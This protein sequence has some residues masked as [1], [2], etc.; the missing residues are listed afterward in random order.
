VERAREAVRK[1]EKWGEKHKSHLV[2]K[3]YKKIVMFKAIDYN[4]SKTYLVQVL[5]TEGQQTKGVR[6]IKRDVKKLDVNGSWGKKKTKNIL[7][8]GY[9]GVMNANSVWDRCLTE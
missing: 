3:S 9:G 1:N 5:S 2:Y 8:K 6:P 4:G 7:G